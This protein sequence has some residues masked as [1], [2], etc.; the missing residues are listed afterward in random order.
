[1]ERIGFT[2]LEEKLFKNVY[3]RTDDAYLYY[4]FT[5]EPSATKHTNFGTKNFNFVLTKKKHTHTWCFYSQ[6][7]KLQVSEVRHRSC[8]VRLMEKAEVIQSWYFS[9]VK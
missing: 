9:L 6:T 5:Y 4:K 8:K 1:M 7:K 2:A 3:V